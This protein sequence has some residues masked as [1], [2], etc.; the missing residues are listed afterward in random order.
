M[1]IRMSFLKT[2]FV[3]FMAEIV[4]LQITYKFSRKIKMEC[5]NNANFNV[6]PF[7]SGEASKV[8]KITVSV[9]G[10]KG[11]E[12][13]GFFLVPG[14]NLECVFTSKIGNYLGK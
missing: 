10:F 14:L 9:H 5:W 6:P 7:H 1:K 11:S 3:F 13:Q 8:I 4:K 2:E 12:V